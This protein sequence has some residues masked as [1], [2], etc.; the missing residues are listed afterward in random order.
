MSILKMKQQQQHDINLRRTRKKNP[1]SRRVVGSNPIWDSDFFPSP[2]QINIIL[3]V[4]VKVFSTKS[5][6]WGQY[7]FSSPTGDG[8][9]ILRGH[10]SHMK[11]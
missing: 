5:T 9:T 7:I 4:S 3:F 2:P 10:P 8:A 6:Y 11:V 1:R